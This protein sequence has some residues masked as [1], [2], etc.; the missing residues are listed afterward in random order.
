[1]GRIQL[2][3]LRRTQPIQAEAMTP[4][5]EGVD[6]A[7]R[8]RYRAQAGAP[9]IWYLTAS[10]GGTPPRICPVMPGRETTAVV[11]I[12]ALRSA[13]RVTGATASCLVASS[14]S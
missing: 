4:V 5:G 2:C 12:I 13:S 3:R 1:M 8:R 14:I 9:A 7:E 11:V 10:A 6:T